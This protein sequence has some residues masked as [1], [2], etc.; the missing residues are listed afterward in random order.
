MRAP[1]AG[2]WR[3][4]AALTRI[5]APQLSEGEFDPSKF[6]S[7]TDEDGQLV[8]VDDGGGA[9]ADEPEEQ[10][11][12]LV[13]VD[14]DGMTVLVAQGGAPGL[15]SASYSSRE[16]IPDVR[17]PRGPPRAIRAARLAPRASRRV[18]SATHALRCAPR[19]ARS[20]RTRAG[21]PGSGACLT[22]SCRASQT[23]GWWATPTP[24]S[25]R[26]WGRS[27]RQRPRWQPIR[28]P[29]CD[30]TWDFW[31][32]RCGR[33]GKRESVLR[34]VTLL[35]SPCRMS[36]ESRWRTSPVSGHAQPPAATCSHSPL[37]PTAPQGWW[38]AR[39]RTAAWAT[40]SCATWSARRCQ[41]GPTLFPSVRHTRRAGAAVRA[42]RGG[43]GGPAAL[44]RPGG[45]AGGAAAV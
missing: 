20:R 37:L 7:F 23:W 22:W 43:L 4:C 45:A 10:L 34:R 36:S 17:H 18:P 40:T 42:G 44:G 28:S 33:G 29:P 24:A 41:R 32:F 15:G 38:R 1:R 25:P 3:T 21:S 2:H 30:R 26:Y 6:R 8:Y 13:E 39:T 16:F 35:R 27:P 14:E 12:E 9:E 5:A 11:R 19:A 31:S